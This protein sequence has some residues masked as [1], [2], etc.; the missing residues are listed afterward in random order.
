MATEQR[1]GVHKLKSSAFDGSRVP[2]ESGE[3]ALRRADVP[4]LY[5]LV[6]RCGRQHAV[7]VL[8]P[9]RRQYLVRMR[10]QIQR[11]PLLPHV[12]HLCKA[13]VKSC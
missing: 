12:P 6:D 13:D 1:P 8:A 5:G 11:R 2:E 3:L 4:Q 10:R 7:V 9:V